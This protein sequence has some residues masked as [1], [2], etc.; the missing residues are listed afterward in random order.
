M[1]YQ[2][3]SAIA[4]RRVK[5]ILRDF[6]TDPIPVNLIHQSQRAQPL[7]RRAFLDFVVPRLTVALAA[8]NDVVGCA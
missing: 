1:S 3:A 5:T 4:E 2:A 7:K 6:S 8:V